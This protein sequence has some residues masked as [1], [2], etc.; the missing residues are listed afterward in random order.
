MRSMHFYEVGLNDR[1]LKTHQTLT[2]S[3][4]DE[5]GV[6]DIVQV[7]IRNRLKN[8]LIIEKTTKP[9]YKTKPIEKL[10][11]KDA[12]PHHLIE[13]AHWVSRYYAVDLGTTLN[14]VIPRGA[15]KKR[16]IKEGKVKPKET[17]ETKAPKLTADQ[18]NALKA[19]SSKPATFMLRGVT[20][21]GKT[22]VYIELAK[23]QRSAGKGTIVLVP[24]IGLTTQM[25]TELQEY[26]EDEVFVIH[27]NQTEAERH[28]LWLQIQQA[29]APVVIGPR[30]A[31][32]SPV[33][34][35]G[36][37]VVDEEH[38]TSY[39]QDI[40]PK[41]HAVRVA[42]KLRSLTK[43]TLVLGSATPN[44]EDYH[45]ASKVDGAIIKMSSTVK[46]LYKSTVEVVD[47]KQRDD[48]KRDRWLSDQ[49]I[50]NISETI[51]AGNQTILFH[52]RRGNS[53]S[54]V[55]QNCGWIATCPNC[56]L[57][58]T[59]HADWGKLACHVCNHREDVIS[60]CKEC[61]K[62]ELVYKGAG[63][64]ELVST[65]EK[66]FPNAVVERFDS[67]I[68]GRENKLEQR[69]KALVDGEVDIIVGTQMIAKGLDLPKLGLVGVALADTSLYLPDYSSN[70][71]TYQLITQVVGRAGRHQD[72]KVVIQTY[73]PD[74][75][76]IKM[77]V[78]GNWQEFY[79]RELADRQA[80]NYPPHSFLLKL[81]LEDKD[82]HSTHSQTTTFA[83]ML[84]Q[85]ISGV[86]VLGPS[87]AFH[88][89]TRTGWRW[90]LV[91]KSSNRAKLVNIAQQL[92]AKWQFELDPI[93][94]L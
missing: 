30:S 45:L 43:S 16:R 13:L 20:G 22:R 4:E 44:V 14:L 42:S 69:H 19:V 51:K 89:K 94:L 83:N 41:Y 58:L 86:E 82:N 12:V 49:L 56:E 72:G 88:H 52:N 7:S 1:G 27:S 54:V 85:K 9:K 37:I 57:P 46:P 5:L 66:L 38:E 65:V 77:A 47:I 90:Q 92:P 15:E 70:E 62:P 63:T 53:T 76:S 24:E 28:S 34:K 40:S 80:A 11:I 36:L 60:V 59:H 87:P 21:S 75:P 17:G 93:N 74:S 25:V 29:K 79:E 50:T 32:F 10:I 33:R 3:S 64:K 61:K 26:I 67:D 35:L 78:E 23:K 91:I 18:A 81:T 48:F 39:K 8:G 73:N 71:R 6:G 2:Y 55:C 68:V 31:L 84:K